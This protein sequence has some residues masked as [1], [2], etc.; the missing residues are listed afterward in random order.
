MANMQTI[1]PHVTQC[2]SKRKIIDE[3]LFNSIP[4]CTLHNFP[5]TIEHYIEW[6]RDLFNLY[7]NDYI[8]ELKNFV[9]NK[10]KFYEELSNKDSLIQRLTNIK[11]LALIVESNDF[12]KYK[13]FAVKDYKELFVNKI[14]QLLKE[15][16]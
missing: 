13:E 1:V 11:K 4:M 16:P 3:N 15:F 6:G 14:N 9:E 7:F 5:S 2:Y 10:E 12:D 8:I